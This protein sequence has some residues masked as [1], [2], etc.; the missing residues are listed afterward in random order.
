LFKALPKSANSFRW[1]PLPDQLRD[2]LTEH[3]RTQGVAPKPAGWVDHDLIFP[4]DLGGPIHPDQVTDEFN[5]L[6]AEAGLPPLTGVH[7][8][9]HNAVSMML[10]LGVPVEEV[11]KVTGHDVATLRRHYAHIIE[12]YARHSVQTHADA[13]L[14]HR[15]RSTRTAPP[16]ERTTGPNPDAGRRL[17]LVR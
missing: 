8:L 3:R 15:W 13:V 5:R 10:H 6:V 4:D 2:A 16:G 1:L 12:R 17:R 9:R 14:G 7:A 11:A